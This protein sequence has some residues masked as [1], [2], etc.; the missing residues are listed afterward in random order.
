MLQVFEE[1]QEDQKKIGKKRI[2]EG[3]GKNKKGEIGKD[4]FTSFVDCI[5]YNSFVI[6]NPEII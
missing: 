2:E 4:F 3:E 1:K 5:L 6:T